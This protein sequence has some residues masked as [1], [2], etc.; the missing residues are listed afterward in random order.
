V[1]GARLNPF[2]FTSDTDLRFVLLIVSVLG[3]ALLLHAA[4]FETLPVTGDERRMVY[5]RCTALADPE[6]VSGTYADAVERIARHGRCTADVDRREATWVLG[7]LAVLLLASATIY[8]CY[9]WWIV[10]RERFQPLAAPPELAACLGELCRAAGLARAPTFLLN[11]LDAR[12]NGLAFG[13]LG[14]YFVG[15]DAGLV[16]DFHTQTDRPL[17]RAVV[18][19]ELAHLR[20]R[21]VDKTYA[22]MAVWIA[23]VVAAALPAAL[24]MVLF[25]PSA[26]EMLL[27]GGRLLAL[28]ALVY[29]TRNAVLRAR[30]FYADLRASGWEAP[31]RALARVL[32][33]LPPAAGGG[34]RRL[35]SSHPDPAQRLRVLGDTFGLFQLSFW[36][37]FAAGVAAGVAMP[38]V[39]VLLGMLVPLEIA[40]V[41]PV[42]AALLFAPLVTGVVGLGAWRATFAALALRTIPPGQGRLGVAL[43]TGF[44]LGENLSFAA[45]AITSPRTAAQ[46]GLAFFV[47]VA[48]AGL[49]LL[50][51]VPFVGWLQSCAS[52]WIDEAA[53]RDSPRPVYLATL[54]IA[55][56]VLTLWLGLLFV[57]YLGLRAGGGLVSSAGGALAQ[58]DEQ[59]AS[60][61]LWLGPLVDASS[62][63]TAAAIAM[64]GVLS[65]PLLTLVVLW[66]LPLAASLTRRGAA[67]ACRW[68]LMEPSAGPL[69]L[70]ARPPLQPIRATVIGAGAGLVTFLGLAGLTAADAATLW[71]IFATPILAQVVA[72]VAAARA[73]GRARTAHGLL[74]A[75]VAGVVT[76]SL[77]IALAL[78]VYGAAATRPGFLVVQPLSVLTAGGFAAVLTLLAAR[79][80][81]LLGRSAVLDLV[82][83]RTRSPAAVD[84]T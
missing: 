11:P 12:H 63:D 23:F 38:N 25:G 46:G 34:L 30:E 62:F 71:P 57:V 4:L 55:G 47:E 20:N 3:A 19:H 49:L 77:W 66:A 43:A 65:L 35:L 84:P 45:T 52:V 39:V 10:R 14:H 28:S 48:W 31:D 13:R 56:G 15:L 2:A 33:D 76:E 1:T 68:A 83:E 51:L 82:P 7:G 61:R 18:L 6:D 53:G 72:A 64:A 27:L 36:D 70:P 32:A 75:F 22:A 81:R 79:L 21:D 50:L 59:E 17:F 24:A 5:E 26:G 40:L 9:P 37:A 41:R 58:P 67:P 73:V 80:L 74:A 60:V 44:V 42:L 8:W 78:V 54:S 16:L 29:L 69:V